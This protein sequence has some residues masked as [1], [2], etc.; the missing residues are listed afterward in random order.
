MKKSTLIILPSSHWWV[1]KMFLTISTESSKYKFRFFDTLSVKSFL[2]DVNKNQADWRNFWL[3]TKNFE[4]VIILQSFN[5]FRVFFRNRL[6]MSESGMWQILKFSQPLL[7][8][9]NFWWRH[10]SSNTRVFK[11]SSTKTKNFGWIISLYEVSKSVLYS[12]P[13]ARVQLTDIY[14]NSLG[15]Q[16]YKTVHDR[17]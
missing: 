16:R 14:I 1:I 3:K 12:S 17:Q 13:T 15:T 10:N 4:N 2:T 11:F 9:E 5:C 6:K 7:E 8:D